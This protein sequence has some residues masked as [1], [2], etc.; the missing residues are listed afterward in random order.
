MNSCRVRPWGLWVLW[1]L[2]SLLNPPAHA[3][4]QDLSTE[5]L[6]LALELNDERISQG[7]MVRPGA[8][9]CSVP[10]SALIGRLYRPSDAE[11]MDFERADASCSID[12]RLGVARLTLAPGQLL[13]RPI[14]LGPAERHMAL[15]TPSSS[16]AI[17]LLA[18]RQ[19]LRT[20]LVVSQDAGQFSL[21]THPSG[22]I[23]HWTGQFSHSRGPV[24]QFGHLVAARSAS[25]SPQSLV[26]L[27]VASEQTSYRPVA[28]ALGLLELHR[29][30]RIRILNEQAQEVLG[31]IALPI[32]S[33][34]IVGP[35]PQTTPGLL[36]IEIEGTDGQRRIEVLPWTQS[37]QLLEPGEVRWELSASASGHWFGALGQGISPSDSVWWTIET[38]TRGVN[39]QWVTRRLAGQLWEAQLGWGC[40]PDC[41]PRA[42]V[43]VQGSLWRGSHLQAGAD[44][45]S[46]Y[47]ASWTGQLTAD[48]SLNLSLSASHRTVQMSW[49]AS[50][51]SRLSLGYAR[52]GLRAVLSIQW[53]F[54]LDTART[55]SL[56]RR[57]ARTEVQFSAQP[58]THGG[59]GWQVGLS[60]RS[61]EVALRQSKPWGDWSLQAS[62]DAVTK[63]SSLSPQ[64]S[65]RLWITDRAWRLGPIGDY[66]LVEIDTGV[67]GV[68]WLD[69]HG[70]STT[71]D[72][73]G[74]VAFTR[75]PAHAEV[76]FR[77]NPR[78]AP[79]NQMVSLQPI[80]ARLD[81]KRFYQFTQRPAP[82]VMQTYRRPT[83][84]E[85]PGSG[86]RD[87]AGRRV[88]ISEDGYVDL[89]SDHSLPLRVE[90]HGSAH[91]CRIL[92]QDDGLSWIDSVPL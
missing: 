85:W 7:S 82:S 28:P 43:T 44:S 65:S 37:P 6:L 35:A 24:V 13:P 55:L 16:V 75:A 79:L 61:Q 32:G 90:A 42:G 83:L 64:V 69:S 36:R 22:R 2:L 67:P 72:A 31:L 48:T 26:G 47:R 74:V 58:A 27:R 12:H 40:A 54:T 78:R 52:T 49:A 45:Q 10:S 21:T 30:S 14:R 11:W 70:I 86:L 18:N 25:G 50:R 87:A 38:A 88:Y 92:A 29:P 3:V 66:N 17:D 80:Q 19:G 8:T 33:Y 9:G 73:A 91:P 20:G 60:E 56:S 62:T 51:S 1:I 81:K 46:G 59:L 4:S 5:A 39:A 76:Q 84:A 23:E 71:A 68:E 77:M 41:A 63:R 89:R 53:H 34:R 57:D 15:S